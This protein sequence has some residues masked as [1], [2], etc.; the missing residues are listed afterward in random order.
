MNR[1]WEWNREDFPSFSRNEP[2]RFL[3]DALAENV[4][5]DELLSSIPRIR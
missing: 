3:I 5:D 4:E 1:L 2:L